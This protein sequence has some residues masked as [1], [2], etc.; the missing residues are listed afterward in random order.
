MALKFLE[1]FHSFRQDICHKHQYL[2]DSSKLSNIDKAMFT[3][4]CLGKM[5]LLGKSA[6]ITL[7]GLLEKHYDSK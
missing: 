4:T 3:E 2:N 1:E 7:S 6:L 5:S